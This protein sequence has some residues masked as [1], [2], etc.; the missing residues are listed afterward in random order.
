VYVI[1]AV[2]EGEHYSFD[3]PWQRGGEAN[4]YRFQPRASFT[5][6]FGFGPFLAKIHKVGSAPA[7]QRAEAERQT[8][9]PNFPRGLSRNVASPVT[10]IYDRSGKV[11]GYV[12]V[13]IPDTIPLIKFKRKEFREQHGVTIFR[14]LRIFARLRTLVIELHARGI[15]IGDFNDKNVLIGKNDEVYLID[16]DS[17]QY[18]SWK[19]MALVPGFADSRIVRLRPNDPKNTLQLIA[20]FD[21]L[22]DWLAFDVMF[23]QTLIGT[24][25]QTGGICAATDMGGK[26]L[27]GNRRIVENV[28]VFH[29]N[30]R[31]SDV[32]TPLSILPEVLRSR[33]ERVFSPQIERGVFP[34]ELFDPA[35][36]IVCTQCQA[37]HG[38]LQCPICNAPGVA[39]RAA[40]RPAPPQFTT[41]DGQILAAAYHNGSM[42]YLT[43]R[44]GA[45]RREDG[46]ELWRG[47]YDAR[48]QF[49]I[50][51]GDTIFARDSRFIAVTS[52]GSQKRGVQTHAVN[53]VTAN[54]RHVYWV[55]TGSLKRD[56]TN[57]SVTIGPAPSNLTSV[58]AGERFGVAMVQA[59]IF[60]QILTFDTEGVGFTG[61]LDLPELDTI[62]DVHCVV[63]DELAWV[64]VLAR[65]TYGAETIYCFVV[66]PKA[67]LIASAAAPRSTTPWLDA[68]TASTAVAFR[69]KLIVAVADVGLVRIGIAGHAPRV[70]K[71][72]DKNR[73]LVT[74][75]PTVGMYLTNKGLLHVSSTTITTVS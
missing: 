44:D 62:I 18:G 55:E 12:M 64:T 20:D 73:N 28:S 38:C 47:A 43:Y 59:G 6:R 3:T 1:D 10:L 68:F 54:S 32:A 74:K 56:T 15:V 63:G 53:G 71:T 13:L 21:E 16:A 58:W 42:R 2:I 40:S 7:L 70:E 11:I 35:L 29:P 9:L 8:K 72:S 26:L 67:Q 66:N 39:P 22:S 69:D 75:E 25:P 51:G 30:V 24:N 65:N 48:V 52:S 49:T 4:V 41:L 36:W 19:C 33:W 27:Q 46:T 34:E 57:G 50:S 17:F 23:F 61:T 45:Y 31:L 60:N 37:E 5:A 14:L